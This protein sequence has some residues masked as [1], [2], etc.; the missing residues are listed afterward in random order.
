MLRLGVARDLRVLSVE[1][2][3]DFVPLWVPKG[4]LGLLPRGACE[5]TSRGDSLEVG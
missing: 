2:K 4:Q 3:L 1:N 5:R